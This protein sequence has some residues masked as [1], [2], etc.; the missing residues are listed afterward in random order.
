MGHFTGLKNDHWT[1]MINGPFTGFK[2]VKYSFYFYIKLGQSKSPFKI[3]LQLQYLSLP[4]KV[5]IVSSLH[6][7]CASIKSCSSPFSFP[8]PISDFKPDRDNADAENVVVSRILLSHTPRVS[9]TLICSPPSSAS[10]QGVVFMPPTR[11]A[12]E[13]NRG[14][15]LPAPDIECSYRNESWAFEWL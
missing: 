1:P 15:R 7:R 9:P 13:T 14:F 6:S 2:S 3:F 12:T 4:V 11:S 8:I 10:N 5:A